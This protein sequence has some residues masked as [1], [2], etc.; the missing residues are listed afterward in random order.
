M[1]GQEETMSNDNWQIYVANWMS[2]EDVAEVEF[3]M[4]RVLGEFS[5]E[6]LGKIVNGSSLC[7]A[8]VNVA[9]GMILKASERDE[10]LTAHV[11][12]TIDGLQRLVTEVAETVR[13][14]IPDKTLTLL[15]ETE[16]N[17]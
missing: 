2:E 15:T 13:G 12:L 9:V 11:M 1:T 6:K 10:G 3:L 4:M 16:G 17:A 14:R 7:Y 8:L 5:A